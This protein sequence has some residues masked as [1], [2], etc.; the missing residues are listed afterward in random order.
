M[1][2]RLSMLSHDVQLQIKDNMYSD[3][4]INILVIKLTLQPT[5]T[6][7][8]IKQR[9]ENNLI[10]LSTLK[11]KLVRFFLTSLLL[12]KII[13][14]YEINALI[15]KFHKSHKFILGYLIICTTSIAEYRNFDPPN[16]KY[17]IYATKC[18]EKLKDLTKDDQTR[19][20]GKDIL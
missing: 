4:T 8:E 1:L 18:K 7:K 17:L 19:P 15:L 16:A 2:L 6:A 10:M 14:N 13:T 3:C 9:I 20:R 11:S 12:K 5:L